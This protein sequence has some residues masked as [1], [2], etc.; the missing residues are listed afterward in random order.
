MDLFT[1]LNMRRFDACQWNDPECGII[2]LGWPP[3]AETALI[4]ADGMEIKREHHI[5]FWYI[6]IAMLAVMLIQDFLVQ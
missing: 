5:N 4:G 2:W 3:A 6:V 1:R